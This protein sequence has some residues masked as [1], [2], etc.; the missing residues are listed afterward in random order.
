MDPG[1][2]DVAEVTDGGVSPSRTCLII[3]VAAT[4]LLFLACAAATILFMVAMAW[5]A[6]T[7]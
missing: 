5:A 4:L 3:A 7:A 6:A 2:L 1:R